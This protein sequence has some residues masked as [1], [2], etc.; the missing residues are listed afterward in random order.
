M[1]CYKVRRQEEK[2][3][4][5]N[6]VVSSCALPCF[7]GY[8]LESGE[9]PLHDAVGINWRKFVLLNITDLMSSIW[10]KGCMLMIACVLSDLTPPWWR[11]KVMVY[12]YLFWQA[13]HR[14]FRS[15]RFATKK[16][17]IQY[18]YI[19][20]RTHA[21]VFSQTLA[22]GTAKNEIIERNRGVSM[23]RSKDGR[24]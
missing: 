13:T 17:T 22:H 5:G 1:K 21:R 18:G 16:G 7:G 19:K 10:A 24:K 4:Y 3:E 2:S 8:H 11:E 14:P 20:W 6:K 12:Y 23:E 9:M 15:C